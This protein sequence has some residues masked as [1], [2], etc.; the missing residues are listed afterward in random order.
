MKSTGRN[1]TSNIAD[2]EIVLRISKY[3]ANS[4]IR[5]KTHSIKNQRFKNTLAKRLQECPVIS[6]HIKCWKNVE[7]TE[8]Y[9][10]WECIVL[11]SF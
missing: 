9:C 6:Q 4:K 2:K 11:Q 8:L 1:I 7:D 3:S 5:E 10:L